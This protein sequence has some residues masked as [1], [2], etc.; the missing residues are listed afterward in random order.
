MIKFDVN[1]LELLIVC[2]NVVKLFEV[3]KDDVL[4]LGVFV[5]LVEIFWLVVCE[6]IIFMGDMV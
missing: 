4:V 3:V 2:I 1:D 6:N 5:D